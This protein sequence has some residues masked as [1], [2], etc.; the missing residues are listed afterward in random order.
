MFSSINHLP[1][2]E[3]LE[4]FK[5]DVHVNKMILPITI[6]IIGWIPLFLNEFSYENCLIFDG[7][8]SIVVI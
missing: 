6:K 4:R 5:N 3:I 8:E 7:F 2:V 1:I